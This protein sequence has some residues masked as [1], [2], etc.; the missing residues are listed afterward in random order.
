MVRFIRK[1]IKWYVPS[2][3]ECGEKKLKHVIVIE[4][5]TYS[6]KMNKAHLKAI[7]FKKVK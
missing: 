2:S 7:K 3:D 4:I 6:L 5:V 1:V